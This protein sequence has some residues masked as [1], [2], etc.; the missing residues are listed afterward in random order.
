[1]AR[2]RVW[3]LVPCVM[4]S[5]ASAAETRLQ[6]QPK[7]VRQGQTALVR[8]PGAAPIDLKIQFGTQNL[9]LWPCGEKTCG[10][11]GVAVDA[12]VGTGEVV[13]EWTENGEAKRAVAPIKVTRGKFRVNKL[14]V[15]PSLT[16]PSEEEKLRIEQDKKDIEA[17]LAAP[18]QE[19]FWDKDFVLPTGGGVTSLFGNQRTYNG[20][21]KSIHFGVDLRAN[22]KTPIHAA[23]AG[24]VVL[25][26][27]FFMAGNMVLIDHGFGVF[28]SYAHLSAIDVAVG[29][30]VK[31]GEKLGMAGATGRVTGPHLHWA[32]RVNGVSVD[33]MQFRDTWNR[34]YPSLEIAK[35]RRHAEP[36]FRTQ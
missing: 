7:S 21:V 35:K 20:E 25:A 5:M 1:M 28:S 15:D 17:A 23:N 13:A 22:E 4:G 14:S 34:A 16:R 24:K 12:P 33:P 3:F 32:T 6:L 19:I 9:A 8:F 31:K 36:S 2:L 27:G 10:M 26:R 18:A 29:A 30:R 11:V